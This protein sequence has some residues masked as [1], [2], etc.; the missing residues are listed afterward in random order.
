MDSGTITLLSEEQKEVVRELRSVFLTANQLDNTIFCDSSPGKS[1]E[2]HFDW[3]CFSVAETSLEEYTL[4]LHKQFLMHLPFW[5]DYRSL[6]SVC[7]S[8]I[9]E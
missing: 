3:A 8:V 7:S 4:E 2:F 1:R 9:E 6:F 5:K